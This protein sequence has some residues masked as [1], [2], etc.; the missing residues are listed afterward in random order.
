MNELNK[1]IAQLDIH[2]NILTLQYRTDSS[3]G[4]KIFVS[5]NFSVFHFPG[6][7]GGVCEDTCSLGC[8]NSCCRT[9]S[10]EDAHPGENDG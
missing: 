10:S 7:Q 6:R 3:C 5:T 1:K 8:F 2:G 4:H 9:Y